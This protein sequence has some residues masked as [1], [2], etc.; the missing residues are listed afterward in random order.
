MRLLPT[1]AGFLDQYVFGYD[2]AA[3]LAAAADPTVAG[4]MA[5]PRPGSSKPR[6]PPF[7]T[8]H[9]SAPITART[10]PNARRSQNTS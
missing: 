1:L 8:R 4:I 5:T 3:L 7:R 9:L 6:S 2:H 10:R